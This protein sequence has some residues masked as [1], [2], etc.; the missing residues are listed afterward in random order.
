MRIWDERRL[1][2][3]FSHFI[4]QPFQ[5]WTRTSAEILGTIM[6][7]ADYTV[8]FEAVRAELQRI[9]ESSELWDG[10]VC[11]LQVVDASEQTVHLRALISAVDSGT[12]WNLRC[13]CASA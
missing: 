13:T 6:V 10:R 3:P 1:I 9:V 12:A 4:Q 5:N 11:N 8:P 2:V 7:Y